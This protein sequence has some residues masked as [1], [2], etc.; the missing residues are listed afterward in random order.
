MTSQRQTTHSDDCWKLMSHHLCTVGR[1]ERLQ[2]E[3]EETHSSMKAM[4]VGV[5]TRIR[6]IRDLEDEIVRLR[7]KLTAATSEANAFETC[8]ESKRDALDAITEFGGFDDDCWA[9]LKEQRDKLR[10]ALERIATYH[11]EY[12][13]PYTQGYRDGLANRAAIA[14]EAM[15]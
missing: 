15:E 8:Y 12:V 7:A 10:A 11:D 2:R 1:V 4:Q 13:G 6:E 3:L 14:R 9:A 5:V